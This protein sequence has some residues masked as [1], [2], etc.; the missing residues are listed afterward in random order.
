MAVTKSDRFYLGRVFDPTAGKVTQEPLLYDPAD[1]TTH[2]IVTG[3]TGS[4]KTGACIALLEEAALQGFPAIVI[5]PKGDLTNLLLHFPDLKPEDF[6]PWIDPEDARRQGKSV[7]QLAEETAG[8]WKEGLADWGYGREQ[9]LALKDAVDFCVYTPGSGAGVPVNVLSSFAAPALPWDENREILREEIASMVSA[10][11]GLVGMNNIDPLRSREHM[12]LSNLVENAWSQGHSLDLVELILQVQKPPFERLGAFPVENFFPEKERFDLAMLLNNFLATPSFQTWLEGQPLNIPELLYT[13][14]GKPRHSIFYLAHLEDAERMFFV[15]LLLSAIE[16]WMRTQR[17]ASGLRM[18]VYFDEIYGYLPPVAN[19]P[20][21]P[22]L[23]RLLKQARAFGVGLLLATQNPVDVDY[24]GLSNAGTWIIGRLQTERDKLR[25]LDG[26][27]SAQGGVDRAVYDKLISGLKKRVFLLHNVHSSGPKLFGTRFV[28]N[29]LAGPLTRAQ[30]PELMRL[31]QG[32]TTPGQQPPAPA[33]APTA[34][35]APAKGLSAAPGYSMT[36]PEVPGD[37][38]SYFLPNELGVGQASSALNLGASQSPQAEGILYRPA[39]IAQAEVRYLQRKYNLENS[40]KV[41][42]LV[43]RFEGAFVRWEDFAA[44]PREA[45][46]LH[47]EPLPNSRFDALPVELSDARRWKSWQS[48]FLDWIYRTGVLTLRANEA[49]KVYA[50]PEVSTAEFRELCSQ[51]ARD[52]LDAEL[53]KIRGAYEKKIATLKN[54]V[55]RQELEVEESKDQVGQRRIEELGTHGE[56]LLS[57]LGKRRRSISSSLSKR[58]LTER[59]KASL[60]QERQELE[61]LK[62]DLKSLESEL[63]RLTA[64]AQDRWAKKVNNAGEV[65]IP[66]LK[67]DIFIEQFGVAWLPYYLLKVGDEIKEAPAFRLD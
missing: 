58:R 45:K 48:D 21:R 37:V 34:A 20:S 43:T 27:E 32:Q 53:N 60:E 5:D 8:S 56:L 31:Q 52:G 62:Q 24:K 59:A 9:L 14:G 40:R 46:E 61:A 35:G 42:A 19:P 39:L 47:L 57:V 38:P 3:M 65:S 15:T 12:L 36:R 4:G 2:A 33:A 55:A 18:L 64:E 7:P 51:A 22:V 23:L 13:P 1:L 16:T 10:L 28:L 26:L 6:A 30:I 49:L 44:R 29:F 66:P 17:G 50:G 25:L 11:L 41:A 54:R 63:E 67:K